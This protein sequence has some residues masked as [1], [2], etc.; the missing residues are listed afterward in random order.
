MIV[1]NFEEHSF[2]VTFRKGTKPEA[3][4]KV[5]G[6][7]IPPKK[8]MTMEHLPFEYVFPIEH[9]DFPASHVSFRECRQLNIRRKRM[10]SSLPSRKKAASMFPEMSV[11]KLVPDVLVSKRV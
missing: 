9:G 10:S 1:W 8:K 11:S 2:S 4:N 7:F 3:S 5:F 6:W